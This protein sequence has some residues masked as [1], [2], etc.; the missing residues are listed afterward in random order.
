METV[1]TR[2]RIS[3]GFGMNFSIRLSQNCALVTHVKE[4]T[5]TLN[6]SA[7]ASGEAL[8]MSF[9]RS[10]PVPSGNSRSNNNKAGTLFEANQP[11][12]IVRKRSSSYSAELLR[13]V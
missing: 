4:I 9:S 12:F 8:R 10:Q 11:A 6:S 7:S 5:I 2:R 1:S 13:E 3:K